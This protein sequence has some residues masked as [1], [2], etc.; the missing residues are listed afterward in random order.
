MHRC[1]HT[2]RGNRG[3][4]PFSPNF[5]GAT[6][7][8]DVKLVDGA[9]KYVMAAAKGGASLVTVCG[10]AGDASIRQ[11]VEGG[12]ESGTKIVVDLYATPDP[13]RRARECVDM[14][15]DLIYLHYGGDQQDA[16]PAGNLTLYMLPLVKKVVD[17][18]IGIV[19]FD[20]EMGVAAAQAGADVVL[21]GPRPYLDGPDAESKLTDYVQR[22]KA[23]R[24]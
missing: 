20:T 5:P 23:A 19:T 14:G 21:I 2:R 13:L 12:H 17:V 8:A 24:A 22:V 9:K 18:P 1:F 10:V 6:I 4:A 3:R 11:A 7:F 16:N 15:A